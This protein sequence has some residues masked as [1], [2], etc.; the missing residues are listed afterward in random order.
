MEHTGCSVSQTEQITCN[1]HEI[2]QSIVGFIIFATLMMKEKGAY[3]FHIGSNKFMAI[4]GIF[5]HILRDKQRK[6]EY[7]QNG[8]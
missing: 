7:N 2:F 4:V 3:L 6:S 5:Q 1:K 8:D